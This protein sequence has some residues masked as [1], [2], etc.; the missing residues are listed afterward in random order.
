[1]S[2]GT[3][4]AWTLALVLMGISFW[5]GRRRRSRGR[6]PSRSTVTQPPRGSSGQKPS[7]V[8]IWINEDGSAR[9]L[10]E[11]E[12]TYVDTDYSPFDGARPYV[13]SAY[14]QRDGWGRLRGYLLRNELPENLSIAPAPPEGA[15]RE[16]TPRAVAESIIDLLRKQNPDDAQD[17]T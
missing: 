9:E 2:I 4:I 3:T 17:S 8:L 14:A 7:E 15:P 12:R 1:M 16:Q 13:K 11:A 10:T 5:I 6:S